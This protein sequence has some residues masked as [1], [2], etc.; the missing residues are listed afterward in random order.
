[1]AFEGIT[2]AA[3]VAELRPL[4]KGGLIQEIYQPD[5]RLLTL[6]L[7]TGQR[8]RLLCALS[9]EARLQ[10]TGQ[11]FE[12][13]SVP[14]AFCMLL[15]KHLMGGVLTDI[16]QPGLERLVDLEVERG[17]Q[18]YTLR[19]ELL[20]RRSNA[21]LLQGER[22]LGALSRGEAKRSFRPG[23]LYP[24]LPAQ[25]K[26]LPLAAGSARVIEALSAQPE[27]SL[28][29]ALLAT[30]EGVGPR[31]STELAARAQL[32]A[33]R[34]VSLLDDREL[35][36]LWNAIEV[37]YRRVERGDYSPQLYLQGAQV[38]GCA[39]LPMASYAELEALPL[40]SLSS[41]LDRCY[42][43]Q[44]Q[45]PAVQA[46]LALSKLLAARLK[47]SS[48]ALER[49]GR[50]LA[51]AA[52]YPDYK[53]Q[54][55]LLM[56]QLHRVQP[57]TATVE[58][59]DFFRGGQRLIALDPRLDAVANAQKLYARYKKLKR[60]ALKLER[61]RQSLQRE[62]AELQAAQGRL[63]QAETMEELRA[64]QL[65]LGGELR[66]SGGEAAAVPLGPG[67]P[68]RYLI[69]GYRVLVGRNGRQN[70]ALIRRAGRWD[71]WLHVQDRPGAHVI[72]ANPERGK[73]PHAVLLRAAGLAAYYS[74]GRGSAKVAVSYTQIKYLRKPKGAKP[75][76][77][78][79]AHQLGSLLVVPLPPPAA[80]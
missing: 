14:P 50:D 80:S 5:P 40:D 69:G 28:R 8:R 59:E 41:A 13:P 72:I 20:G 15:R 38:Y 78:L 48:G 61:R 44:H 30:L 66:P 79:L 17:G 47:K 16:R 37:L 45:E 64:L 68:R 33:D 9:E 67:G 7:W 52:K 57:G 4:L 51:Q 73:V 24:P 62:L 53:E 3:M 21:I 26:L 46:R 22:V 35:E 12:N 23:G 27:L 43:R 32:D 42:D 31:W 39:P 18:R 77:V 74:P 25:G 11:Q 34:P 10:L 76:A 71:F 56:A 19:C 65:E 36:R 70:D 6:G 55:D 2:L 63:E 54:A 49:V 29:Q 58:L 75:G 1:M 60:G